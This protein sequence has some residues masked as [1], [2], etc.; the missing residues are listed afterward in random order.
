[1]LWAVRL[2]QDMTSVEPVEP[3]DEPNLEPV[4]PTTMPQIE[5]AEPINE[6]HQRIPK[7]ILPPRPL[8]WSIIMSPHRL[9][10]CQLS[11]RRTLGMRKIPALMTPP[12]EE[13]Y[14]PPGEIP[15]YDVAFDAYRQHPETYVI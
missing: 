14:E 11:I 9:I 13:E 3:I 1:M 10:W 5:P 4:E 2:K 7:I 8:I 6:P 12:M 15:R